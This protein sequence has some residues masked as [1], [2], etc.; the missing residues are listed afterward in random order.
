MKEAKRQEQRTSSRD[1]QLR[2]FNVAF[3]RICQHDECIRTW[4]QI[5]RELMLS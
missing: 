1:D 3:T 5:A 4:K 2:I